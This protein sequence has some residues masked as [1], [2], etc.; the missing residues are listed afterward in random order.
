MGEGYSTQEDAILQLT[1]ISSARPGIGQDDV[2][3]ILTV[4]RRNNGTNR[5]TGMLI[6]DGRRF[7][8]A[9]EGDPELVERTFARIRADH[10]HRA[11]VALSHR[12]VAVR[13]FG[14]WAMACH[15]VGSMAGKADMIEA[16][17][18]LTAG[19][20]DA[21]TRDLFRSFARI[22]RAAA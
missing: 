21:N 2:N 4:S 1:Y 12:E 22:E 11:I 14:E 3:Q 6:H 20:P 17:D 18:A 15:I 10:R 16:V 13:E 19:V 7:L 8:Q 5:I 9:L